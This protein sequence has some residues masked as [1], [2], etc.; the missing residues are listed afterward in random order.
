MATPAVYQ[1]ENAALA[2]TVC[3]VLKSTY[4]IAMSDEN[5]KKA[6]AANK[7]QGRM[8]K[9]TDNIYVDG[10]HNPHGIRKFAETVDAMYA[11][12]D[13]KA[14]LLFSVVS[15]KNFEEMIEVLSACRAFDRIAVTVTGGK[16]Q[17]D[18]QYIKEAF[19]RHTD[20][21]IEVYDSAKAALYALKNE[22][23]VFGVGSL[24]LVADIKAVLEDCAN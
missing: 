13:K 11:H 21:G 8:E 1:A 22:D 5:I 14:A 3:A 9:V 17:L 23:M 24:Y 15:D 7:W 18:R 6:L 20:I 4:G 10:A 19:K 12:S 16:R 2:L